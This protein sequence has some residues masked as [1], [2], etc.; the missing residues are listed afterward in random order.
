MPVATNV[1]PKRRQSIISAPCS[2]LVIIA[3]STRY[4]AAYDRFIRRPHRRR[5]ASPDRAGAG[6]RRRSHAALPSRHRRAARAPPRRAGAIQQRR[7]PGLSGRDRGRRVA[8]TG[9]SAP[10]PAD[11]QDRRVEITGP[12]DRK[13]IINALNSGASVF[14]ADFEDA[15]SPTW[16]NIVAGQ[17]NLIDAIRPHDHLREPRT[18][19][20]R[21][22]LNPQA[23]DAD[24]P[25]AR[26]PPAR[27]PL[28]RRRPPGAG[29]AVRLRPATSST[30]RRRWRRPGPVPYFY[31]PK[32]QS[33]LEARLWNDVFVHA[34]T[35][36]EDPGRDDQGDRADRN[37]AGGVRDGRDPLRAE[38][39]HRRA[40]LRP[41]GLHLQL[42]Q[43]AAGP[44]RRS[45]C[46]IAAR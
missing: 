1:R 11:L 28:P 20:K 4:C 22:A 40:Q 14:M 25:A 30:T 42:D 23:R 15:T 29:D 13:M 16:S 46:P 17:A 38:G 3:A 7:P 21:Y 12:V 24:G 5:R 8:A 44:T 31:L 34:Q 32:M 9:R 35:R 27:A 45:C 43:D 37:A 36:A 39:A 33:H 10:I 18:P 2:R 26:L 6:V 41:L 19:A